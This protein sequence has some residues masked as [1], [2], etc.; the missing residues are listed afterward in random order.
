MFET[1]TKS[2]L[3]SS[4]VALMSVPR[5]RSV[6]LTLERLEHRQVLS[7]SP[8]ALGQHSDL[9]PMLFH[10]RGTIHPTQVSQ[11]DPSQ[12][13]GVVEEVV[14]GQTFMGTGTLVAPDWVLTAAHV[15]NDAKV[16]NGQVQFFVGGFGKSSESDTTPKEA[17]GDLPKLVDR[18]EVLPGFTWTHGWTFHQSQSNYDLALIHLKQPVNVPWLPFYWGGFQEGRVF[19]LVGFGR[20]DDL[21]IP[22]TVG[23]NSEFGVKRWGT[24]RI[25]D[26]DGN[27][28]IFRADTGA[29]IGHGDSGGPELIRNFVTQYTSDNLPMSV[30][31]WSIVGV[32]SATDIDH[33]IL[34]FGAHEV[35]VGTRTDVYLNWITRIIGNPGIPV[36]PS[37]LPSDQ[38]ASFQTSAD[39]STVVARDRQGSLWRNSGFAW[40]RISGDN[41]VSFAIAP[42]GNLYAL[43]NN[44]VV[45]RYSGSGIYWDTISGP[46]VLSLAVAPG[47]VYALATDHV[48]YRYS[49]SGIFWYTMSSPNVQALFVSR[50]GDI[51]TLDTNNT[52]SRYSG[53]DT[54]WP[55][56]ANSLE[57]WWWLQLY[58]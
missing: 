13:I 41:V 6:S 11:T 37:G 58:Y 32:N 50:S 45:Y 8:H 56:V 29:M 49:G 31:V 22:S 42:D 4:N 3:R 19:D 10:E 2:F 20:H 43:A 57:Y 18:I 27:T 55:P 44:R 1:L 23:P 17:D 54:Y 53:L 7:G 47:G 40:E 25:D 38:I 9:T 30:P 52:V 26:T 15:V 36:A 16:F 35:G 21:D 33:D 48:V 39:G 51:F 28:L 14:G 46:N 24:N 12:A 34:F 5:S